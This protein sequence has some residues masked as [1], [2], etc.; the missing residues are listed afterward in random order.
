MKLSKMQLWT[1]PNFLKLWFSQ[2]L[3]S[4]AQILLQVVVMVQVYQITE[5][6]TGAAGVLAIMSLS[7]FISGMIA[8][9]IIDRYSMKKIIHYAGWLRGLF[10]L[11]VGF[12]LFSDIQFSIIFMFL[13]LVFIS[14]INAWY[15]PARFAILPLII[16]KDQYIQANGTLVIIQ[17]LIMTAGWGLGGI[18]A[19]YIWFPLLIVLIALAYILS[20]V[21]AHLIRLEKVEVKIE[22]S[23]KRVPAWKEIWRIPVVRGIT[24]M[25]TVE[26]ISNAI[27]TSAL[28][29][30]FTTVV[31]NAGE[32]WWGFLNAGY[33]VGAILGSMVV[34]FNAKILSNKIGIMI[35]LSGLSM[36]IF[37]ILFSFNTIP[38][39]A[40]LLCVLMGPMYQARDIC[41]VALMQDA[42]PEKRLAG[43]M[44]AR[45]AFLTPWNG[46]MIL[47]VGFLADIIGVQAIYLSAGVLYLVASFIAFQQRSLR[48]YEFKSEQK[49]TSIG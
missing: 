10:T 45:N 1:Q 15:Q 47:L 29:L 28:L 36:G 2:S 27:W 40:V 7:L 31:L 42:I 26:G 8:S 38:I 35:G 11:L 13:C 32:Q 41:Q 24:I 49:A 14:F 25:E 19:V 9:N 44:A 16:P 43:I 33:F 18:L 21:L 46:V 39:I 23:E 20:G 4:L 6:V 30:A 22:K 37:T 5:S 48:E 12:F 17:Q 34:T 3:N